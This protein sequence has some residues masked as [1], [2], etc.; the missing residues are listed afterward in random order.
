MSFLGIHGRKRDI[1]VII[2]LLIGTLSLLILPSLSPNLFF[3]STTSSREGVPLPLPVKESASVED[4]PIVAK[5]DLR[6]LQLYH[7]RH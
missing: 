6:P 3:G 4:R 5:H 7:C 2:L 1:S